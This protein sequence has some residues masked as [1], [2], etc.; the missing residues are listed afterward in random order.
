M[1]SIALVAVT[2]DGQWIRAGSN[3]TQQREMEEKSWIEYLTIKDDRERE[4][5]RE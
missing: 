1:Y 5:E 3:C 2:G 4:R